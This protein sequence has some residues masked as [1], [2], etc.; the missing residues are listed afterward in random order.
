MINKISR[1]DKCPCGSG[2]KYKKC[3]LLKD[4]QKRVASHGSIAGVLYGPITAGREDD[5]YNR[6]M[7]QNMNIRS[8]VIAKEKR[9]EFDKDYDSLLQN[10]IEAKYAKDFCLK[11]I[12]EHK[13]AIKDGK[14]GIVTGHQ[15][16]IKNP[17]DVELNMFFK[18]FFIRGTMATEGLRRL[19]DKWFGY[20]IAFLFYDD[21]KKF[22]KGANA[23]KLD[24][25]DPRFQ[26][27][28]K[29]IK[30][31]RD[32]WY[33]SFKDLRDDIEHNGYKIPQIKHRV[34]LDGKVEI[35]FPKI[36]NQSIE[37]VLDMAWAN[38]SNLC[39]EVFVF[40]ISLELNNGYIIWRV[41]EEKR[42]KYNWV[43]YKISISEFPE[44]E[45]SC[46]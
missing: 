28:I 42:E 6:F 30:S 21:E 41:P 27:L 20:N 34:E 36:G 17:I 31:H 2:K 39:E 4:E 46:S 33:R 38:L 11:H 3:H 29:F 19:L 18:D 23:F 44:A 40:I 26:T 24:R 32:G 13:Q 15:L 7:F 45:V 43:K 12:T 14:D 10:L 1:N 25:N 35:I 22:E 5:F 16:N 8:F 37:E 9:L